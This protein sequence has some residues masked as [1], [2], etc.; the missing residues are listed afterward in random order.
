[1]QFLYGAK[2]GIHGKGLFTSKALRKG[3]SIG[4]LSTI[5]NCYVF[6]DDGLGGLINHSKNPNISLYHMTDGQKI[7]VYGRA[8][9]SLPARSELT[10][11]YTSPLAP[12]PNFV[13]DAD[14]K[15]C[16]RVTLKPEE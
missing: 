15:Y 4:H 1:M 2:S 10:A 3:E 14:A 11:D 7:K 12:K 13:V 5:Y 9:R 8:N 6:K 16:Q